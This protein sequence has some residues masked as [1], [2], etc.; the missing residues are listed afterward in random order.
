MS[1]VRS[2]CVVILNC[3]SSSYEGSLEDFIRDHDALVYGSED[4]RREEREAYTL[5]NI[6]KLVTIH[7]VNEFDSVATLHSYLDDIDLLNCD[8]LRPSWDTYFMVSTQ[9]ADTRD[10]SSSFQVYKKLASLASMRSN[11]MKR[12]VGAILVRNHRIVATGFVETCAKTSAI[13]DI[14]TL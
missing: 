3:P 8:R 1:T 5:H 9:M 6:R 7:V 2:S 11:C 4:I 10:S 12:R 14:Q 13:A